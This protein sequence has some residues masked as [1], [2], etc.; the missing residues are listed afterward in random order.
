LYG[1]TKNR[2]EL[3]ALYACADVFVNTTREDSLSLINV[4]AQACGTPVVTFDATG[5]KETVDGVCGYAVQTGDC[6][7]LYAS[8]M[9][10]RSEGKYSFR[11]Y[12]RNFVAKNFEI[13]TNYRE[14]ISL[15]KQLEH[16]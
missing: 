5:P 3:A 4:E 11:E 2:E 14:Y 1:Y 13:R 12:C 7:Q 6:E 15:Y 8:V 9:I 16:E 10:L